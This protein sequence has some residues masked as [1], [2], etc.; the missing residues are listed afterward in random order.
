MLVN[1]LVSQHVG[2][3]CHRSSAALDSTGVYCWWTDSAENKIQRPRVIL[4]V[5]NDGME[6]LLNFCWILPLKVRL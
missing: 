5:F 4:Q 3:K 2:N 6:F 1:K